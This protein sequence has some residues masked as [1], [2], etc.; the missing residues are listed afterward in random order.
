M[1]ATLVTLD[2]QGAFDALLPNRLLRRMQLQG[3]PLATIRIVRSFLTNRRIR[4]RLEDC[5]TVFY[6]AECGTPQGSPLSP[7]LYM[8]DLA[9]LLQQNPQ[10]RFGYADDL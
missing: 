5:T 1:C 2:V 4:V 8:L 3:W 9:E 6:D 10:F 7:V